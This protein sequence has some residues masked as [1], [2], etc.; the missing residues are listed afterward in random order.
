[1]KRH[2]NLFKDIVSMS[3]IFNAHK[4][5]KKGKSHYKEVKMV[6]SDVYK[7]CQSIQDL[8]VFKEFTTSP[9]ITE[10]IFDR[11][12]ERVIHKLP[13]YPDRI[14]HHS[15]VQVCSPIWIKSLIRDTFQSIPNRGTS[16][17]RDRVKKGIIKHNPTHA[18]KIDIKKFYPNIDNFILKKVIR[19]NIKCKNTLWLIDNIIN[20][21]KGIPIGNYTSQFFGNLYLRKFDWWVKQELLVKCYY[22][23]CD[24]MI[25]LDTKDRIQEIKDSIFSY[26]ESIN[27]TVKSNWQIYNIEK[28]G[29]DFCGYVFYPNYI[30]LR[31]SIAKRLKRKI[32]IIEKSHKNLTKEKIINGLMSY[33]GWIKYCNGKALWKSLISNKIKRIFKNYNQKL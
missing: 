25:I 29:I 13:Y 4:N 3:N 30:K 11:T 1:M 18:L 27:L 20:S 28:E 32:Y 8:L 10:T 9:Y 19:H 26:I 24:D 15:I 31:P 23:Y 22:R 2:G 12:K 16:D 7:H 21:T 17:A 33:W 6:D 14:V 5:A